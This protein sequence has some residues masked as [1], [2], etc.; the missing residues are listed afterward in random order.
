MSIEDYNL[1][2]LESGAF[3]E[4]FKGT[5]KGTQDCF[6]VMKLIKDADNKD[7]VDTLSEGL[8]VLKDINHPNIIKLLEIKQESKFL[9]LICEYYN[10]RDLA[11]YLKEKKSPL[12]EEVVQHIMKQL[13]N[14]IKYL[15]EKKIV[16]RNIKPENIFIDYSSEKDLSEK[17]LLNSKIILGGFDVSTHLKQDQL[18][19]LFVATKNYI[20]PEILKRKYNEK[21][22]IWSLGIA[23]CELLLGKIPFYQ[24][25]ENKNKIN[26]D[27]FKTLSKEARAFIYC[28]LQVDPNNRKTAEELLK[29]DFLVKNIKEFNYTI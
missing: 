10:G 17:N 1:E 4:V 9:Y 28:M 7:I 6:I 24:S 15:H 3:L 8:E 23:F 27:L 20:S 14:A 29:Q 19:D 11:F 21:V 18:L 25:G 22:D 2:K 26:Y 13:I 5:K 12:S 16:H